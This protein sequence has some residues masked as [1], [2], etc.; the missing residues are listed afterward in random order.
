V[1]PSSAAPRR[2]RREYLEVLLVALVV[3]LYART[4]LLQAFRVPSDS[5]APNLVAGDHVVVNK[6]V[7]TAGARW[8]PT[9]G[10]RRNDLVVFRLPGE[11]REVLLKRCVAVGGDRV[12]LLDKRLLVDGRAV[13]EPWVVHRDP[14]VYPRSRFA[15]PELRTRDN[16]G[17]FRVPEGHL[18][19]LGDNRDESRDSRSFGVVPESHVL[20]RPLLVYW[21]SVPAGPA[22]PDGGAFSRSRL[23]TFGRSAL[24]FFRPRLDRLLHWAA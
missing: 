20:G 11:P 6:L 1:R 15:P 9:R 4:F 24:A 13:D 22:P 10:V 12:E 5:M 21:S 8:L 14:H 16:Y 18:F 17:P 19:C 23:G 3:A 2:L 7:F